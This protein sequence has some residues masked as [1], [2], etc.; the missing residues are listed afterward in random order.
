MFPILL[1]ID[2]FILPTYFV[3][4]SFTCCLCIWW[5][6]HRTHQKGL[7]RNLGLD[8]ILVVLV[9]GFLGARLFHIIFEYP[10]LYVDHPERM[11]KFWEG[12][13]VYYGGVIAGLLFGI[14]YVK[15]KKANVRVW[16]DFSAPIIALGY[17]LGRIGCFLSGCCFGES[18]TLPWAVKFPLGVEAPAGIPLHPVQ[19]Y[20]AVFEFILLGFLLFIEKR[21]QGLFTT[22]LGDVFY[23][24]LMLHG[25]GRIVME[26]F[27][28]DYRGP[29]F[30][31]LTLST[32]ISLVM[33]SSG[34]V[35][36]L[37]ES[38]TKSSI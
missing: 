14:L 17:A 29:L 6:T 27:R 4:I 5:T 37:Y 1:Q 26:T 13:F 16:L 8:L 9:S 11:F 22:K 35:L 23:I 36:Y 12:G 3:V 20:A 2:S 18:C 33:I 30:F 15:I 38:K 34:V 19:L 10:S 28:D 7:S 32:C 31:G 21:K 25:L 24:W